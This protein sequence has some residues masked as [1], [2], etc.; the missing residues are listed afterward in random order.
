MTDPRSAGGSSQPAADARQLVEVFLSA[1]A[2]VGGVACAAGLRSR[3][4]PSQAREVT[5]ARVSSAIRI[6]RLLREQHL[7]I[8]FQ[9]IVSTE[10]GCLVGAEALARFA[11]GPPGETP[12]VVFAAADRV[13]LGVDLELLAVRKA[14]VAAAALP[15]DLYIS[16]NVSPAALLSARLVDC[17]LDGGLALDRVVLEVTEHVSVADYDLLALRA[18]E[19]RSL[20]ARIAVDDA[21]AGFASFRHILRLRPDFIKLDRT[22]IEN[23]AEDPARRALAAAV[24]LFALETGAAVVAEGVETVA[25][26]RTAQVLGIDAAQ[27]FL[28]GRPTD[29]W[30]TWSE[31]HSRG[32]LFRL[33]AVA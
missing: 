16:I 26:L 10:T 28:L 23:I 22:L 19:V 33:S 4:F 7:R 20:G 2:L 31:W 18:S 29:N 14:L 30:A 9:P 27:G 15:S 25:E 6:R 5:R 12:D 13:G 17:L 24:M 11:D 21:G 8:V 32:P 3:R 1:M